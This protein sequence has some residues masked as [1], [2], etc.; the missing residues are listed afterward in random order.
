MCW[1]LRGARLCLCKLCPDGAFSCVLVRLLVVVCLID[2]FASLFWPC[3]TQTPHQNIAKQHYRCQMLVMR[4]RIKYFT[5]NKK[6]LAGRACTCPTHITRLKTWY[7]SVQNWLVQ[8]HNCRCKSHKAPLWSWCLKAT[9]ET[10]KTWTKKR[11]VFRNWRRVVR[12]LLCKFSV[13]FGAFSCVCTGYFHAF[14][15]EQ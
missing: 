7:V 10:S 4:W 14:S 5:K 8:S 15:C 1:K 2:A 3:L 9:I 6:C 12:F 13:R 11:S